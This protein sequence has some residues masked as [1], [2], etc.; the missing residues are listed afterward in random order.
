MGLVDLRPVARGSSAGELGAGL[1]AAL[2]GLRS[3][4]SSSRRCR[5]SFSTVPII[6][7]GSVRIGPAP[8]SGPA[9]GGGACG[10]ASVKLPVVGQQLEPCASLSPPSGAG[11]LAAGPPIMETTSLPGSA[12]GD[13]D[14]AAPA[15][16]A[17]VR[18]SPDGA[19]TLDF[20]GTVGG[21]SIE[22]FFTKLGLPQPVLTSA[23]RSLPRVK[24]VVTLSEAVGV[25]LGCLLGATSLLF[26]DLEAAE[27]LKRQ[28]VSSSPR[29]P[30]LP[31]PV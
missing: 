24:L 26:M 13:A 30:Q 17:A 15:G 31:Q 27:R 22:A 20:C 12:L 14:V 29:P 4:S 3:T 7:S 5:A 1:P 10:G 11:A 21:G 16:G 2:E 18:L 23:Q 8:H 6:V 9:G 28:E 25:V 19:R